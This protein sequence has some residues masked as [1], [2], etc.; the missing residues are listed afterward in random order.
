MRVVRSIS[1]RDPRVAVPLY[2]LAEAARYLDMPKSTFHT[3]V[4]PPDKGPP[5]I[6]AFP[7]RGHLPV[8]PFIGFA[9]AFAIKAA[10]DAGV[11]NWRIRPA[12]AKIRERAGGIEHAL[13][14]RVI[15]TDGSELLSEVLEDEDFE[16]L[17]G[18]QNYSLEV[19][20]TDQRTFRAAVESKLR[21][22]TFGADDF[23][24]RIQLPQ[25]QTPVVVDPGIASGKPLVESG[26]APRVKDLLDRVQAGDDPAAVARDFE[27]SLPQLQEVVGRA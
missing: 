13:A 1:E 15:Y 14:S 18:Q 27:V 10:V 3:W 11:P 19:I 21:L 2:T 22:I 4:K 26:I 8:V 24:D 20:R 25:F 9:E 17:Q 12:I 23:A 5:L 6:T 16:W 7:K